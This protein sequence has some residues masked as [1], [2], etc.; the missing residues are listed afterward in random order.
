M[1][2]FC[3]SFSKFHLDE[4]VSKIPKFGLLLQSDFQT[5]IRFYMV[6]YIPRNLLYE[7]VAGSLEFYEKYLE[8][9]KI[10]L[11]FSENFA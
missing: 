10:L 4:D 6:K 11:E 9:S 8:F 2:I 5:F 1:E 7:K 3:W